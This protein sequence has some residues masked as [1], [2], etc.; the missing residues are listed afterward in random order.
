MTVEAMPSLPFQAGSAVAGAAGRTA[1]WAVS[2]YMRQPLRNTALAAL[3][4]LSAMAGSNALY[5]Q[6]HHHPAP[7]F[8]T[9][10]E[11]APA[12]PARR[13]AASANPTTRPRTGR[14]GET[15][16]QA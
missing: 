16:A 13:S 4:G 2:V 9:F 1:L 12:R 8:G 5:K 15:R 3:V 14:P 7:L 6:S 10:D 11:A